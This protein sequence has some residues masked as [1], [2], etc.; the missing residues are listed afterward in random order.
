MQPCQGG[1]PPR[2]HPAAVPQSSRVFFLVAF[3]SAT[4][5]LAT[6][7]LIPAS[8]ESLLPLQ[9]CAGDGF[10]NRFLPRGFPT[11]LPLPGPPSPRCLPCPCRWQRGQKL[12]VGSGGV[13][14]APGVQPAALVLSPSC[15]RACWWHGAR[16]ATQGNIT[17]G[18]HTAGWGQELRCAALEFTAQPKT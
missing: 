15:F 16:R 6:S 14:G 2:W 9:G 13:L 7:L 3:I 10:I 11:C 4:S 8:L 18:V 5:L 1:Q 12:S 17:R